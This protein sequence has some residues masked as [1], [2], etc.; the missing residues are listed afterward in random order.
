MKALFWMAMGI[1]GWLLFLIP[2]HYTFIALTSRAERQRAA[3]V[4]RIDRYTRP[5]RW[6]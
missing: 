6:R 2:L 5:N 4:R 1:G 3:L